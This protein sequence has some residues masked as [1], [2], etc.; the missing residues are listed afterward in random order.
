MKKIKYC[1]LAVACLCVAVLM[2]QT[3]AQAAERLFDIV[4]KDGYS[5]QVIEMKYGKSPYGYTS[6][7]ANQSVIYVNPKAKSVTFSVKRNTSSR[8]GNFSFAYSKLKP[9]NSP[10]GNLFTYTADGKTRAW[11]FTV[12][13]Y[14][15]PEITKLKVSYSPKKGALIMKKKNYAA[16]RTAIKTEVPV[17]AV[18]CILN[19]KGKAVYKKIYSLDSSKSYVLKWDGKPSKGNSAKLKTSA[20]VP[21]GEYTVRVTVSPQTGGKVKEI[22]EETKLTVGSAERK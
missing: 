8:Y 17:K 7:Y 14:V 9:G 18:L 10:A 13:K 12:Q 19:E 2:P 22:V 15:E 6:Y 20:Y 4:V 5:T 1:L 11:M 16:I 3:K 21:E